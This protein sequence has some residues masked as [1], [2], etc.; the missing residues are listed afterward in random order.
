M[1]VDNLIQET[2]YTS[3]EQTSVGDPDRFVARM[4]R[5]RVLVIV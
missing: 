4:K 3:Y 5:E 2:I 1:A